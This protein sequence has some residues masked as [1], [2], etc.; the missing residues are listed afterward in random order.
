MANFLP[1][2]NQVYFYLEKLIKKYKLGPPFLDVGCGVGDLSRNLAEKGWRGKAID[3]SEEAVKKAKQNLFQFPQIR[4]EKKSLFGENNKFKT[5]FLCDVL[6]HLENDKLA[7]NKISSLL[8]SG[9]FLFIT[10]PSN[11]REWRW[12][13]DF[14]GHVRRYSIEDIK[15]KIKK[16]GLK[17]LVIY[18]YTFPFFW[19]MRRFYTWVK[20]IPKTKEKNKRAKTKISSVTNAWTIPILSRLINKPSFF[21]RIIFNIQ[22]CFFKERVKNGY[23][24]LVLARKQ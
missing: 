4:V 5:I 2:N 3:V 11:L 19:I 18:D 24:M 20:P 6:E 8:F 12:D 13:D 9:G 10:V 15:E 22:F 16:S 17:L 23:D 14:Y 1:L 7:L 21:W